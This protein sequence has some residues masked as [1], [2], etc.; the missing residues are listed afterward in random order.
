[1]IKK[2]AIELN[3][4][5]QIKWGTAFYRV[6]GLSVDRGVTK[7]VDVTLDNWNSLQPVVFPQQHQVEVWE[8]GD[9][10]D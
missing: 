1:M 3:L 5:D 8:K 10:H 6:I 4:G 7:T 2:K 9:R